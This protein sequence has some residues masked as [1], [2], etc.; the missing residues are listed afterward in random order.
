MTFSTLFTSFHSAFGCSGRAATKSQPRG[1]KASSHLPR[2]VAAGLRKT[3]TAILQTLSCVPLVAINR[4]GNLPTCAKRTRK[5]L[6]SGTQ[7]RREERTKAAD[8]S[9]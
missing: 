4:Y 3:L 2:S 9:Q 5:Q 6:I 1:F 8:L 7:K